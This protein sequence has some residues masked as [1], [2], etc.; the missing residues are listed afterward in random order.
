MILTPKYTFLQTV[1]SWRRRWGPN[2]LFI[3]CHVLGS[4]DVMLRF[5]H[6][7]GSLKLA[8]LVPVHA[9][10]QQIILVFVC[11][12]YPLQHICGYTFHMTYEPS[13][14]LHIAICHCYIFLSHQCLTSFLSCCNAKGDVHTAFV[15]AHPGG[16]TEGAKV[17]SQR[18]HCSWHCHVSGEQT[19]AP[20]DIVHTV[21]VVACIRQK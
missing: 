7:L 6:A 16:A 8:V 13:Q 5:I 12:M 3:S 21:S 17:P 10:T 11:G 19:T 2:N 4:V 20:I 18:H 1:A 15:I 9:C 14:N